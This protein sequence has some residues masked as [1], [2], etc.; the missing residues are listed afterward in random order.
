MSQAG[1]PVHHDFSGT[2]REH[3]SYTEWPVEHYEGDG[4]LTLDV[5]STG[6]VELYYERFQA[7]AVRLKL[8]TA[9]RI[10]LLRALESTLSAVDRLG[11][12]GLT[13]EQRAEVDLGQLPEEEST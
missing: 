13:A 6:M 10:R 5:D 1:Q 11:R 4:I 12:L 9:A 8:D 2:P 7:D 3:A